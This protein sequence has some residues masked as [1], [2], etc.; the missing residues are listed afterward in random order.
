MIDEF[1]KLV[2]LEGP[3]ALDSAYNSAPELS[4]I[5]SAIFFAPKYSEDN[6]QYILKTV[7]EARTP[8]TSAYLERSHKRLLKARFPNIYNSKTH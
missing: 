1:I 3:F 5:S 4:I 8:A 7:L 2:I 6:L